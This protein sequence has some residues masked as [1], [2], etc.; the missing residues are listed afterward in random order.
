[1]SSA[2]L[3]TLVVLCLELNSN[4][5][6]RG[7]RLTSDN[8]GV[9]YFQQTL[10]KTDGLCPVLL[11]MMS[12]RRSAPEICRMDRVF[13]RQ[14]NIAN[15]IK[16]MAPTKNPAHC[17]SCTNCQKVLTNSGSTVIIDEIENVNSSLKAEENVKYRIN[18]AWKLC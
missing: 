3:Q 11:P 1:M 10:K 12:S 2:Y 14:D 18:I 17:H 7:F 15:E 13:S 8:P 16:K 6:K 9:T 4:S 5:P